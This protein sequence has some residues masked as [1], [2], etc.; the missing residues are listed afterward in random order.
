MSSTMSYTSPPVSGKAADRTVS[1]QDAVP[2]LARL[3][4]QCVPEGRA[5]IGIGFDREHVVAGARQPD[6]LR[7][8]VGAHIQDPS[9]ML[10]QVPVQ[11]TRDHL[12][13]DHVANVA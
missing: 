5:H 4:A 13:P 2:D 8:L 9:R 11:L 6:G 10:R 7:P 1:Q 12:L 3:S